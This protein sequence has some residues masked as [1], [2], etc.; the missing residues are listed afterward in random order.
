MYILAVAVTTNAY[1]EFSKYAS[2]CIDCAFLSKILFNHSAWP[3][4]WCTCEVLVSCITSCSLKKDYNSNIT[5]SLPLSVC[6]L[7][8]G[9]VWPHLENRLNC[10]CSFRLFVQK[11]NVAIRGIITEE[12]NHPLVLWIRQGGKLKEIWVD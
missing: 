8:T 6:N 12:Y 2:S 11:N 10:F 7:F 1:Q 4:C 3:F 5:Y 9:S